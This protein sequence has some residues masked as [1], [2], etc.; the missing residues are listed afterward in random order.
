MP[1]LAKVTVYARHVFY[2]LLDNMIKSLKPSSATIGAAVVSSISDKMLSE[3]DFTFYY[4]L[5]GAAEEVVLENINPV[6]AL[7]GEG[8][9]TEKYAGELARD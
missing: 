2:D 8:S 5:D 4:D 1:D 3:H 9:I 6:E 7:L